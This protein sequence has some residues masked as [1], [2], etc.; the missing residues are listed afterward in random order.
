MARHLNACWAEWSPVDVTEIVNYIEQID[1]LNGQKKPEAS[2]EMLGKIR[3]NSFFF[4]G[5][6]VPLKL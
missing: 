2:N 4:S 5:S 3:R 6:F 1:G